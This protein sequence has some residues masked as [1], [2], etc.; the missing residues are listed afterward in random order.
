MNGQRDGHKLA[1]DPGTGRYASEA[2]GTQTDLLHANLAPRVHALGGDRA[3]WGSVP[4]DGAHARAERDE[5][6]SV[7]ALAW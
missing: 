5:D 6:V 2:A 7:A 4:L 3:R 1:G